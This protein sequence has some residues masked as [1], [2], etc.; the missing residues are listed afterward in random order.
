MDD[1]DCDKL[2]SDLL[3]KHGIELTPPHTTARLVD[4][5]V[6][7]FLE[8]KCIQPTFICDHPEIMSP[9]AKYHRSLPSMTERYELFVCGKEVSG[10]F[11]VSRLTRTYVRMNFDDVRADRVGMT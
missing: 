6:G 9:L 8:E 10:M 1:P 7:H 2:L 4:A 3:V 5:L 11:G